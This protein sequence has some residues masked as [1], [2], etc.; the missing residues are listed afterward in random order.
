MDDDNEEKITN[1]AE[2][3]MVIYHYLALFG[4]ECRNISFF[5]N[6]PKYIG[7]GRH[8]R[9]NLPAS[10][11][12][13]ILTK[14][15]YFLL[16]IFFLMGWVF[17]FTLRHFVFLGTGFLVLKL[18]QLLL[19]MAAFFPLVYYH[20]ELTVLAKKLLQ[21][22]V[23]SVHITS[24]CRSVKR[25]QFV[26]IFVFMIDMAYYF[27]TIMRAWHGNMPGMAIMF[28][29]NIFTDM[30][31]MLG[32]YIWAYTVGVIMYG[33]IRLDSTMTQLRREK[34]PEEKAK[35]FH[36]LL[37]TEYH[38][39][40]D[41]AF[42]TDQIMSPIIKIFRITL[43]GSVMLSLSVSLSLASFDTNNLFY[44]LLILYESRLIFVC[45]I[46]LLVYETTIAKISKMVS[47]FYYS[48]LFTN[49]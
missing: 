7:R 37:N 20:S 8:R 46:E 13:S 34:Q 24:I 9:R 30:L 4:I 22:R 36:Y 31:C 17:G 29:V 44:F 10:K 35:L 49:N 26:I 41:L 21:F 43:I 47:I 11:L 19:A 38:V 25:S 28:F 16:L 39:L 15:F 14:V 45:S 27:F 33:K 48:I 2:S 32:P 18:T 12:S 42:E 23:E 40:K 3:Q 5:V 1:L 6:Q